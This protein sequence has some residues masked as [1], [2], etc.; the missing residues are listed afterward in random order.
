MRGTTNVAG[1]IASEI[2]P[3]DLFEF[4]SEADSTGSYGGTHTLSNNSGVYNTALY[5]T[6]G[7]YYVKGSYYSINGD[8]AD[9]Y[10][11]GIIKDVDWSQYSQLLIRSYRSKLSSMSTGNI[12]LWNLYSSDLSD[13]VSNVANDDTGSSRCYSSASGND[14][15]ACGILGNYGEAR[16]KI[17]NDKLYVIT[18]INSPQYSP[19]LQY[20]QIVAYKTPTIIL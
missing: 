10:V 6:S 4:C 8:D 9:K 15:C 3:Y 20:Y 19:D 5:E 14:Y 16:F 1:G 17:Q 13:I 18:S 7:K 11:S 12:S 2:T